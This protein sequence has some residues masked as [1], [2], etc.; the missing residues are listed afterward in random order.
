[1][2][3]FK[4]SFKILF[5]LTIFFKKSHEKEIEK[6][7]NLL[8]KEM[9]SCTLVQE[10]NDKLKKEIQELKQ[11]VR[12][13]ANSQRLIEENYQRVKSE[14]NKLKD[15]YSCSSSKN[16]NFETSKSFSHGYNFNFHSNHYENNNNMTMDS[17]CDPEKKT[18][19]NYLREM[20]KQL[21][22]MHSSNKRGG[23]LLH[24]KNSE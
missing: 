16:K 17:A 22:G 7:K 6:I 12:L 23:K 24:R 20:D 13:F 11:K 18:W 9:C 3:N 1:M 14:N 8:A 21:H 4:N 19:K 5:Y 2:I 15:F 10:E